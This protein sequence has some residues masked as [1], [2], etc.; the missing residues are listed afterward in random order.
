VIAHE[1]LSP[2]DIEQ[3]YGAT[4]GHVHHGEHA[5]DQWLHARPDPDC[6]RYATPIEGLFLCGSGSHP[7]G[8]IS[9]APGWL[10]AGAI[11]AG[12]PAPSS[13]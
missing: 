4:G 6:A 12:A 1:A 3:R 2:L 10:A 9:C 11:A 8:G 5:L 13:G 7:G